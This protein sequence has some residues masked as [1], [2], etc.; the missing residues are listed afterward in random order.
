M[1][2]IIIFVETNK[3]EKEKVGSP[4][5]FLPNAVFTFTFTFYFL[6]FTFYFLILLFTSYFLLLLLRTNKLNKC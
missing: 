2:Q 5:P 1:N 6:L 4:L 3:L